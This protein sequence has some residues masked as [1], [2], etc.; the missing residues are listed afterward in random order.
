MPPHEVGEAQR[1]HDLA[2]E[3][4]RLFVLEGVVNGHARDSQSL[5]SQ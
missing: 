1:L 4:D 5:R 3:V 2:E